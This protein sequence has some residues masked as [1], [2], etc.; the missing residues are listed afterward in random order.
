[1]PA[2]MMAT[3]SIQAFA[4]F[5]TKS[6]KVFFIDSKISP[7]LLSSLTTN[8]LQPSGIFAHLNS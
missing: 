2:P 7:L 6:D 4:S 1:M 5:A 3:D 8:P